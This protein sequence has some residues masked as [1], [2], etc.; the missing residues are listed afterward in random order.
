LRAFTG[1][2][3]YF[4]QRVQNF[5]DHR[6]DK[7]QPLTVH[8][9]FQYSDTPDFPHGK[10]Q[11][12]REAGL[13]AVDPTEYFTEGTFVRLT[14]PLYT[15]AQRVAIERKFPEWSSQRHM[16]LDA[17]QRATVRDLLAL[18]LALNATMIMPKFMCFCDRYWG[19]TENCRMPTAPR[20][21][22]L[23]FRCTQ[24]ALFEIKFWNDK[25]V[26]FREADFLD[27]PSVAPG[28]RSNT[29][30][31]LVNENTPSSAAGST[32]AR[33]TAL[34][35]PATPMSGVRAAVEAVNPNVRLVEVGVGDIRRL[36]KWL[37]S[38]EANRRFNSLA[39]YVLHESSRYCPLEDHNST[40]ASIP[41]W[42]WQNPFT[43]YNCTWGFA[44]P[45]DFPVPPPGTRA[46][47]CGKGEAGVSLVERANSTTCPRAMLCDI[48]V[49][50]DG[51][52]SKPLENA[53]RCNLEGY[54]GL[55]YKTFGVQVSEA[56][57]QYPG[58]RC[59]Y[60]PGDR[61]GQGFG[62]GFDAQGHR[63]G[64]PRSG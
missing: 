48:H 58:G 7:V 31:L 18:S 17:I 10:R 1:G 54:G 55:D 37:G 16:A 45:T 46:P 14:G 50:P 15:A 6:L 28:I 8:F 30:R 60:P 35:K 63:L 21:M 34:L 64:V 32:E 13:W 11:R 40:V 12:A 20:D 51:R 5:D 61:P 57:A 43:A 56:L 22:P 42:N 62:E 36:C 26:R 19:F 59:P 33:Y 49:D 24:D 52:L 38:A 4:M 39:R 29:V 41:N 25:G 53:S 27:H 44:T 2:H 9:T 3:T 23:P 47:P